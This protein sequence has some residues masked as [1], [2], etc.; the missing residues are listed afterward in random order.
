MTQF[1]CPAPIEKRL[2][3][4]CSSDNQAIEKL[5]LYVGMIQKWQTRINLVA[6]STLPHI[7]ERHILDSAQLFPLIGR[8]KAVIDLGSGGGLPGL[9]LAMLGVQHITLIESD[10]RK[11]VFLREVS[12]ETGLTNV[13]ILNKRLEQAEGLKAPV[14]TARA[15]A[16]LSQ[17]VAWATAFCDPKTTMLFPK[18]QDY[19]SE[20]DA[21]PSKEI[22]KIDVIQS[23]TEDKAKIVRLIWQ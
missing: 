10:V 14:I 1:K 23:V 15:L 9:V 6:P 8:D 4:Y 3:E 19:Q 12:R 2:H 18:G 5:T 7:W 11:T 17:L 20:I 16:P 21:L 13:T 22:Y